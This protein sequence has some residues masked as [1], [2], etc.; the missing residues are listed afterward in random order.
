MNSTKFKIQDLIKSEM[1]SIENKQKS[2]DEVSFELEP[3]PQCDFKYK[4]TR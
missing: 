2:S 4:K 1:P 3:P